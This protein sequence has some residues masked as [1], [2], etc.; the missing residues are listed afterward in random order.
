MNALFVGGYNFETPPP[1]M[2]A[3]GIQP[4]PPTGARKLHARTAFFYG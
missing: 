3:E 2:T 1:L 4:L